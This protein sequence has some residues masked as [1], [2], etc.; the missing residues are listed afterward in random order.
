MHARSNTFRTTARLDHNDARRGIRRGIGPAEVLVVIVVVAI[1]ALLLMIGLAKSREVARSATCSRN[2]QQIGLALQ[3]YEQVTQFTPYIAPLDD[4]N[5]ASQ[6]PLALMLQQ[7]GRTEVTGIDLQIDPEP[8]PPLTEPLSE[9]YLPDF[10]CPS[11]P[12]ATSRVFP[13]PLNYRANTGDQPE[14][15]RGPFAPGISMSFAEVEAGDGAAY[16]AAFSERL[17]GTAATSS[18]TLRDYQL[19]PGPVPR[20][21]CPD[22]PDVLLQTEAGRSWLELGWQSTLYTHASAPQNPR[23]CIDEQGRT[24][25][26]GA[27]SGHVE[28]VRVLLMDGSVRVY[29]RTINPAV[30]ASLGTYRSDLTGDESPEAPSPPEPSEP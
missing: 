19:V 10:V 12:I 7:L 17:V 22:L 27:S 29:A 1:L 26:M 2:L 25:L 9:R 5:D 16:T 23:S 18:E 20:E 3:L 13:A 30:W 4:L 11:D 24:A 28:G 14:G 8:A 15:R 6:G 21:G